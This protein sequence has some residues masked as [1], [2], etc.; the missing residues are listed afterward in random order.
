MNTKSLRKIF[1][2]ERTFKLVILPLISSA[3]V[4]KKY[5]LLRFLLAEAKQKR[6]RKTE[7]YETLLQTYLFA[8]FPSALISLQ[9]ASEY[10]SFGDLKNQKIDNTKVAGEKNCKKIYGNKFKKLISNVNNF[11]SELSA[12]LIDEGYGKVLSRKGLSLKK[13]ELNII[14]ILASLK[15]EN[16]LYSHINGAFRLGNSLDDIKKIISSLCFTGSRNAADF[17]KSVFK[18]FLIQKKRNTEIK[19]L[20]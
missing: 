19:I 8:G 6:I 1:K 17:G 4:L 2:D 11:S 3:S 7:I 18:T 13:R 5:Q 20:T 9:I 14:A 10:F 12:W 15:F 16:Q